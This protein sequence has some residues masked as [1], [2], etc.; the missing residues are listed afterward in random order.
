MRLLTATCLVLAGSMYVREDDPNQEVRH[1][2]SGIQGLTR[3]A[4]SKYFDKRE[5]LD[6]KNAIQS[7]VTKAPGVLTDAELDAAGS[8]VGRHAA[9]PSPTP[10]PTPYPEASALLGDHAAPSPAPPAEPHP[11]NVERKFEWTEGGRLVAKETPTVSLAPPD[12]V[13]FVASLDDAS[14]ALDDATEEAWAFVSSLHEAT[15]ALSE[16]TFEVRRLVRF[17]TQLRMVAIDDSAAADTLLFLLVLVLVTTV[18][19]ARRRPE[20]VVIDATPVE[21]KEAPV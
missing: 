20:P 21:V 11:F 3:S 2:T 15:E 16:V 7:L 1:P 12:M 13:P 8:H 19:C 9:M 18:C 6:C 4:V 14:E 5:A 10:S 17:E